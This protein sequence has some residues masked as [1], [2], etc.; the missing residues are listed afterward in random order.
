MFGSVVS[1]NKMR[2]IYKLTIYSLVL[3]SCFINQT[4]ED[5]FYNELGEAKAKSFR[6]LLSSYE[7]FLKTN[8]PDQKSF[9]ER[10]TALLHQMRE[11]KT[12]FKFDR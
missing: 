4:E 11:G 6:M 2:I 3:F 7:Q 1:S 9:N 10:T 8:F 12:P 5:L